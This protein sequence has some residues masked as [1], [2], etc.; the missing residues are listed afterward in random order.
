MTESAENRNEEN[1][2]VVMGDYPG[3]EFITEYRDEI[4]PEYKWNLRDNLIVYLQFLECLPFP[5][6]LFQNFIVERQG[7]AFWE[8]EEKETE[9]EMEMDAVIPDESDFESDDENLLEEYKRDDRTRS[10]EKQKILFKKRYIWSSGMYIQEKDL[11]QIEVEKNLNKRQI[12][13]KCSGKSMDARDA[14]DGIVRW[15]KNHK[16][17]INVLVV[18]TCDLCQQK[19]LHHSHLM[20]YEHLENLRKRFEPKIQCYSSGVMQRLDVISTVKRPSFSSVIINSPADDEYCSQTKRHLFK[21]DSPIISD[22][23]NRHS[24]LPGDHEEELKRKVS[25]ADVAI[26]LVSS[27]LTGGVDKLDDQARTLSELA[28]QGSKSKK[29]L[30][31]VILVSANHDW[32]Q[33][34]LFENVEIQ[35]LNHDPIPDENQRAEEVWSKINIEFQSKI[36]PWL[37]TYAYKTD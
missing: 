13:V 29:T 2:E 24:P 35:L 1:Q 9:V 26:I 27:H 3:I 28:I 7:D 36:K 17:D 21:S 32:E 11:F 4:K 14:F 15:F 31:L 8:E 37:K 20:R 25:N 12:I 30:V 18:C 19:G 23:I 34:G 22:P 33:H 10:Y 16:S 5:E 6:R